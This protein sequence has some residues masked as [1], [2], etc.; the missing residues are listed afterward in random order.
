MRLI[1]NNGN[2]FPLLTQI[3]FHLKLPY[4]TDVTYCLNAKFYA[5]RMPLI[6]RL[7]YYVYT[8][9]GLMIKNMLLI[10]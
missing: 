10:K 4:S 2:T 9:W 3:A 8:T 1:N 7:S 6:Q 5:V